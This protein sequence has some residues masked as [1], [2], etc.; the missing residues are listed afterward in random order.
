MF[1]LNLVMFQLG[2]IEREGVKMCKPPKTNHPNQKNKKIKMR[3]MDHFGTYMYGS[4][5][6]S[7]NLYYGR[8]ELY[9]NIKF[10]QGDL[11]TPA[12]VGSCRKCH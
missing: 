11:G 8:A 12:T 6:G 4:V 3:N 1:K 2:T 7:R 5:S 9:G 10:F